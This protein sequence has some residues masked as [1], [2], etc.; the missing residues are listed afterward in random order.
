MIAASAA[1]RT[2]VTLSGI[3]IDLRYQSGQAR[4][5]ASGR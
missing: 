1:A 2:M 3:A 5:L 4:G